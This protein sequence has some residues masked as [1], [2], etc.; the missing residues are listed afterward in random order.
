MIVDNT[1]EF[2]SAVHYREL[3]LGCGH[4]RKKRLS[5]PEKTQSEDYEN[6]LFVDINPKVDPDLVVD[7]N[8]TPW[9]FDDEYYD[10]VHAYEILEHLGRQGDYVSFFSHFNE[11]YRVL[12]PG[13]YLLGSTPQWNKLWAWSDPGHTRVISEGTLL[14]LDRDN[15]AQDNNPMTDYRDIYKGN[16]KLEGMREAADSLYFALRKK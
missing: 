9:P 3:V 10:E 12:K 11:I 4:F 2:E 16:F 1:A 7:L 8:K 13:G 6:A 15:Y 14:F 5:A